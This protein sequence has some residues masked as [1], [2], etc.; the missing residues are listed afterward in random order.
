M[1][2]SY[3]IAGAIFALAFF[4]SIISWR[5]KQYNKDTQTVEKAVRNELEKISKVAQDSKNIA[6]SLPDDGPDSAANRLRNDWS[7]D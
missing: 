7:R 3:F 5:R 2:K 4:V 6:G 1:I